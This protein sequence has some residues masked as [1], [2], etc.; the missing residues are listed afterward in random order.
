M[1]YFFHFLHMSGI[2]DAEKVLLGRLLYKFRNSMGRSFKCYQRVLCVWKSNCL[3]RLA[4]E[5]AIR[6]LLRLLPLGH[7]LPFILVSL[8]SLARIRHFL[9]QDEGI[10]HAREVVTEQQRQQRYDESE[11]DLGELV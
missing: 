4:V 3:D 10:V 5:I 9:L 1:D 2:L 6:E 11:E 8:G 7:N